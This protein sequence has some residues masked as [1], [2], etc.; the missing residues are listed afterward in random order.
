MCV[1]CVLRLTIAGVAFT[2]VAAGDSFNIS[3]GAPDAAMAVA[4][5]PSNGSAIEIEAADDFILGGGG[6][7]LNGGTFTGLLPAG[8]PLTSVD[9]VGVEIYRIFPLDSTTPPSG[10]VPTR[11]N[12]PSDVALDSRDTTAGNLSFVSSILD[13]A[14]SA[15]NSVLNGI[16][17]F[18]NQTTN[19][20]GPVRGEEAQFTF[21]LTQPM[22]L[23]PGHYF[24]VPQVGLSSGDFYWLSSTEAPLFTGD[25]QAWV[26]NADL[27]PDWLR[28]GTDIVGSSRFDMAFSLDGTTIPEPESVGLLIPALLI[29]LVG[30]GRMRKNPPPRSA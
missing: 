3:T 18:P 29:A 8:L 19:G 9:F 12:S 2:L 4:S 20:E 10:H 15:N 25:L 16:R 6:G 14:F 11:N 17:P 23:A 26:R 21:S 5:R 22:T 27:D 24:F 7:I 28:V 30:I 1:N 13:T